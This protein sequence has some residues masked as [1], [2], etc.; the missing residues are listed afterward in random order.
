[1]LY[2]INELNSEYFYDTDFNYS[3]KSN[4]FYIFDALKY[5]EATFF[6]MLSPRFNTTLE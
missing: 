4:V 5:V 3:E 6:P 1:M 2:Q